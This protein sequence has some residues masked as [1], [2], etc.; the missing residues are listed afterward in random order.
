[1]NSFV[2]VLL[3]GPRGR[4]MCLELALGSEEFRTEAQDELWSTLFYATAAVRS[5]NGTAKSFGWY[6]TEASDSDG[7]A[8][9]PTPTADEL[10]EA[11]RAVEP[12]PVDDLSLMRALVASVDSA[13][14]WQDPDTEDVFLAMPELA[15]PLHRIAHW[16]ASSNAAGWMTGP[17]TGEQWIVEFDDLQ[18]LPPQPPRPPVARALAEWRKDGV[19]AGGTWWSFPPW[20]LRA[21]TRARPGLGP[22]GLWA[23]E[24]TLGW[25]GA[26]VTRAAT[27]PAARVYEV[28]DAESWADLCRAY[29]LELEDPMD[30]W[31]LSTGR[32]G[33]WV[34]PDWSIVARDVDA[35]H[36][37]TAAYLSA[38]E[39]AIP[40][41]PGRASMIAGW[42]PD[43]TYWFVDDLE[44]GGEPVRW[45]RPTYDDAWS[46]A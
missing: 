38:A 15:D 9:W 43:H 22:I 14:P 5:A 2:D 6:T 16:I 34:M 13:R 4:R 42:G 21:T 44:N 12:V 39:T 8:E 25:L 1:M 11:L 10:A 17:L 41:S 45:T 32:E 7:P 29:P 28:T 33:R 23:V 31:R 3:L 30:G 24:D 35:V 18:A 27:P 26:A 46:P 37:T 36:L 40:V 20:P 19:P